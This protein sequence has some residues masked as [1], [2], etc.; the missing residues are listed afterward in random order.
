[1]AGLKKLEIKKIRNFFCTKC[2]K[3]IYLHSPKKKKK[4][5]LINADVV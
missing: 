5:F 2:K 4:K 3:S 1:M